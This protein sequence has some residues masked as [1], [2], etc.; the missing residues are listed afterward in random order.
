MDQFLSN[1]T[2]KVMSPDYERCVVYLL[3]RPNSGNL[4]IFGIRHLMSGDV[5]IGEEICHDDM[6]CDFDDLH[7]IGQK[8]LAKW[9]SDNL[10][11]YSD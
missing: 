1:I 3:W 2:V 8:Y 9:F 5:C 11:F 4:D 6:N 10:E 7:F